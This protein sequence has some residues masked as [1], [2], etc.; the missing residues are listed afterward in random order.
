MHI[1]MQ[2]SSSDDNKNET[3][4]TLSSAVAAPLQQMQPM[5][6]EQQRLISLVW[7]E[8]LLVNYLQ[9]QDLYWT[10]TVVL[11]LIQADQ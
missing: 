6:N 3:N 1:R 2:L 8:L 5:S 9:V 7:W 11:E 4:M 10:L